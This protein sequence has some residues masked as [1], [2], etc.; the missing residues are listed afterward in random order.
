[1]KHLFLLVII[2]LSVTVKGQT[3]TGQWETYDDKTQEKK[4]VIEIYKSN[5]I[6]FAKIVKS[7]I[8]KKNATCEKCI[9]TKKDKPIIGLVVIENIKKN[10]DEFDGGSILDPETG[11]TYKCYLK[12]INT[13]KLE[14]RGYIGFSIFGRTQY[15][16]RKE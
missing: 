16:L 6:Y 7:F 3:I 5:N 1:M 9:G 8:G 10:E 2:T 12:L 15:W 14:V 13:N 4:A 11:E